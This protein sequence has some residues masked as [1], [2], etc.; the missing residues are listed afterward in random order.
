MRKL[1]IDLKPKALPCAEYNL[2]NSSTTNKHRMTNALNDVKDS[3][4]ICNKPL[5]RLNT[6]IE[7]KY[8]AFSIF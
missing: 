7:L 8:E 4:S 6:V 3:L 1:T 5:L 2:K